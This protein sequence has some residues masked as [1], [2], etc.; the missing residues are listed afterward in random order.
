MATIVLGVTGMDMLR[1]L[2]KVVTPAQ[3]KGAYWA[4]SRD[5]GI[6]AMASLR[7]RT[8]SWSGGGGELVALAVRWGRGGRRTASVS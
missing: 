1:M 6:A 8:Y 3:R 4:G 2:L 7:R 5:E